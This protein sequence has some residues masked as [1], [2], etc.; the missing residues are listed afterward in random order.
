MME[1][2]AARVLWRRS[3]GDYGLCYTTLLSD[4][5]AKTFT[6]LLKIKPYGR[7]GRHYREGGVCQPCQQAT[8]H[9]TP[10]CC[11]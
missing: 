5:D 7:R 9:R 3:V 4:G 10:Q 11:H 1:V 2:E 6:E 8:W